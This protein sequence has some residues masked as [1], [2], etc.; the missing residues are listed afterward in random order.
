MSMSGTGIVVGQKVLHFWFLSCILLG[1]FAI[2]VPSADNVHSTFKKMFSKE[3]G[4]LTY[5]IQ[6]AHF[7]EDRW[8]V[9]GSPSG[10]CRE[11]S[12]GGQWS[13]ASPPC[14]RSLSPPRAPAWPPPPHRAQGLE[15]ENKALV[16]NK[17]DI[18]CICMDSAHRRRN[19]MGPEDNRDERQYA[20][21]SR[22]QCIFYLRQFIQARLRAP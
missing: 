16:R 13:S 21:P 9:P 8:Q 15:G 14:P 22:E 11:G 18:E 3:K 19:P 17:T 5:T 7:P 6:T 4:C 10:L 1:C 20:T 12:E 2:H